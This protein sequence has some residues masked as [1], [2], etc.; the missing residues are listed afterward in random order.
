MQPALLSS[1]PCCQNPFQIDLRSLGCFRIAIALV[2]IYDVLFQVA[3]LSALYL[4]GGA[5]PVETV[6]E[7][8]QGNWS[9]SLHMLWD[10]T[11]WQWLL[12]TLRLLAGVA[13]LTGFR[14]QLAAGIAWLLTVSMHTR[15]PMLVTGGDVLLAMM[16]FWS[17][18]L[19]IGSRFSLD[20]R[21]RGARPGEE[22]VLSVASVGVMLQ[23]VI[24]YWHTAISKLNSAWLGGDALE[25]ILADGALTRPVGELMLSMPGLLMLATWGTLA[26][27]CAGPLL[28]LSPWKTRW[29]RPIGLAGFVALHIGIELTMEVLIFSFC[30]LAA[31][32]VFLPSAAW[33]KLDQGEQKA[34]SSAVRRGKGRA[35]LISSAIGLYC[36]S[37]LLVYNVLMLT[38]RGPAPGWTR[39]VAK[40]VNVAHWN[41][42]WDMFNVP[43]GLAYRFVLRGRLANG[44]TMD[45][46]REIPLTTDSPLD[47]PVNPVRIDSSRLM[48]LHR[49]MVSLENSIFRQQVAEWLVKQWNDEHA[50]S[51]RVLE[52]DWIVFVGLMSEDVPPPQDLAY[53]DTRASGGYKFGRRH[54][55]WV[56]RY[57]NGQ[58]SAEGNY[59]QDREEGSWKTWDAQGTLT[60][61]GRFR[62]GQQHGAWTYFFA[63]GRNVQIIYEHGRKVPK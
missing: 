46:G 7:Y 25:M 40:L 49:E 61:Q 41:Q 29:L 43:Q 37:L 23:L 39:I 17:I 62:K 15:A 1:D 14:S 59:L 54:G 53:V 60:S 24:M 2:L 50:E 51:D 9:W 21:R 28:L 20:A 30:S 33:S 38:V 16:L 3:D 35:Q 8:H 47:R 42:R 34:D 26:W 63:D 6:R 10:A 36:I 44:T 27:E 48:L 12:W 13:L 4:A 45:L 58:K 5:L 57:D 32:L 52:L 19:P 22:S 31:L 56:L 18:M 55:H 11:A